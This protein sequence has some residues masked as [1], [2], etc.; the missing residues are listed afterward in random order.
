MI[1]HNPRNPQITLAN[2]PPLPI[3]HHQRLNSPPTHHHWNPWITLTIDTP[4]PKNKC[5]FTIYIYIFRTTMAWVEERLRWHDLGGAKR[6]QERKRDG[7][8]EWKRG[9]KWS[10]WETTFI[11]GGACKHDGGADWISSD[12]FLHPLAWAWHEW[13]RREIF[14]GEWKWFEGKLNV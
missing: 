5:Y 3:G 12:S 6:N 14:W 4:K 10:R 13:V 2:D 8:D 11:G 1:A 9:R 7:S